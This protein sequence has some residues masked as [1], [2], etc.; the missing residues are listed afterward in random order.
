ME[1][2]LFAIDELTGLVVAVALVRPSKSLADLKP[3]SVKKKWKD[4]RFAAG[5]DRG[6]IEKGAEMLG[7]ELAE[8]IADVIEGMKPVAAEIGLTGQQ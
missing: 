7:V 5:V 3:K 8:L 1:K 4:H 6:I 2:T